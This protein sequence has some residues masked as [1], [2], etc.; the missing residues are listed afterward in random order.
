MGKRIVVVG[1]GSGGLLPVKKPA[2][3]GMD[4][5]VFKAL[6]EVCNNPYQRSGSVYINE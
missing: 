4:V 1:A 6:K 5:T 2:Q 3:V